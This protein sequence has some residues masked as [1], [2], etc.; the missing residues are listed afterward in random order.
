MRKLDMETALAHFRKIEQLRIAHEAPGLLVSALARSARCQRSRG[1]LTTEATNLAN[2]AIRLAKRHGT[3]PEHIESLAALAMIEYDL[4]HTGPAVTLLREA[5]AIQ[6]QL[7]EPR[8]TFLL[9]VQLSHALYAQGEY[10]E[11]IAD[12]DAARQLGHALDDAWLQGEALLARTNCFVDL[13]DFTGALD[14]Y[15]D[16][17]DAAAE[18]G[19]PQAIALCELNSALCHLELGD[20]DAADRAIADVAVHLR[21][22]NLP[23]LH[24]CVA[25]YAGLIAEAHGDAELANTQ[26]R[27]AW[28]TRSRR[29]Q[30]RPAL[31]PLAGLLRIATGQ[32][33]VPETHRLLQD[34]T[35]EIERIGIENSNGMDG[36]EHKARLYLSLIAAN[37]FLGNHDQ[38]MR[39][40]RAGYAFLQQQAARISDPALRA[41]YLENVPAHRQLYR[42]EP[43]VAF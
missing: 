2:R 20:L 8:E 36:V 28:S 12:A 4:G 27:A 9:H 3:K 29:G 26:F 41:S 32:G 1:Y 13:G 14:A 24:S 40:Q 25:Y 22:V 10:E 17:R 35:T 30:S 38:A 7:D 19:H 39:W 6:Q 37:R 31:D 42:T 11:A 16:A 5:L 15:T 21:E 43:P 18:S 34:V 23:Q 33:N